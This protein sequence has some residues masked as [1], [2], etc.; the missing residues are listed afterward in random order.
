MS[1]SVTLSDIPEGENGYGFTVTL[2]DHT[3]IPLKK[4]SVEDP[5]WS[6]HGFEVNEKHYLVRIYDDP[7][8]PDCLGTTAIKLYEPLG[9]GKKR[10]THVNR[11]TIAD[12]GLYFSLDLY[13]LAESKKET[14]PAKQ[15]EVQF[16]DF[17]D[18]KTTKL[19]VRINVDVFGK[20][21]FTLGNSVNRTLNTSVLFTM[22]GNGHQLDLKDPMR[23]LIPF[24]DTKWREADHEKNVLNY[25][26]HVMVF[27]RKSLTFDF[28]LQVGT[29]K[30]S[31]KSPG[32]YIKGYIK[33]HMPKGMPWACYS[34]GS[35]MVYI[36]DEELS[37]Y[38][39]EPDGS[40][41]TPK[42]GE[43][44][45]SADKLILKDIIYTNEGVWFNIHYPNNVP[46][47]TYLKGPGGS[48]TNFYPPA[49]SDGQQIVDPFEA[50]FLPY[51]RVKIEDEDGNEKEFNK[52][53]C[54]LV[55]DYGTITYTVK[56]PLECEKTYDSLFMITGSDLEV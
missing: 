35:D 52:F 7:V 56:P 44:I 18:D 49:S 34:H 43:E 17:L 24:V 5:S 39:F 10:L 11:A 27:D 8:P 23:V 1:C 3:D 53:D 29:F 31:E 50:C 55:V 9:D 19:Q 2:D 13:K 48:S 37:E 46:T 4:A 26:M 38:V 15:A 12:P 22:D 33:E 16:H 54:Y 41:I 45:H 47:A 32:P 21:I 28:P 30:K 20:D 51:P 6:G 36:P 14:E 40:K 42:E 25:I